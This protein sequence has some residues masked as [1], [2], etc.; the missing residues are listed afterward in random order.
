[1]NV[2][3][4]AGVLV[5]ASAIGLLAGSTTD[6]ANVMATASFPGF[7]G[8]AAPAGRAA[9]PGGAAGHVGAVAQTDGVVHL[10]YSTG[11]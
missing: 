7:H 9:V 6:S 8:A 1:M 4:A 10:G 2:T 3:V 5:Q 11:R